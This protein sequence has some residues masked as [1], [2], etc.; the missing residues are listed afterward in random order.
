MANTRIT[1]RAP[2]QGIVVMVVVLRRTQQLGHA[3]RELHPRCMTEKQASKRRPERPR[4][5]SQTAARAL[6]VTAAPA[7]KGCDGCVSS[8]TGCDLRVVHR[9]STPTAGGVTANHLF[10]GGATPP[11]QHLH[12]RFRSAL[13]GI[14]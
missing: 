11:C 12:A 8:R 2:A 13:R 10:A 14:S 9:Q 5:Q 7:S 4:L 1:T 6:V 3:P